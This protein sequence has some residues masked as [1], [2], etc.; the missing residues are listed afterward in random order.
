MSKEDVETQLGLALL[1][2]QEEVKKAKNVFDRVEGKEREAL[3]Y[4]I[5]E[6]EDMIQLLKDYQDPGGRFKR[7]KRMKTLAKITK[8]ILALKLKAKE[9]NPILEGIADG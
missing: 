5:T 6:G 3:E 8:K 2:L 7:L 4:F 1:T 9:L